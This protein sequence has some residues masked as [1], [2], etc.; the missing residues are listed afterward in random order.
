[1]RYGVYCDD[2][3]DEDDGDVCMCF[4]IVVAGIMRLESAVHFCE[5]VL[6][7]KL[8][9]NQLVIKDGRLIEKADAKISTVDDTLAR[10]LKPVVLM[11][12]APKVVLSPS[13][14]SQTKLLRP[15]TL[16]SVGTQVYPTLLDNTSKLGKCSQQKTGVAAQLG[17]QI[18]EKV[19]GNGTKSEHRVS[20]YRTDVAASKRQL[21]NDVNRPRQQSQRARQKPV[22]LGRLATTCLNSKKCLTPRVVCQVSDC[23]AL[24]AEGDV[25]NV[26]DDTVIATVEFDCSGSEGGKV[27]TADHE[28]DAMDV[29]AGGKFQ[30][31]FCRFS[32][33]NV[34]KI[35]EHNREHQRANNI[36]YYCERRFGSS[37]ELSVHV[38]A[39]H[40]D[41]KTNNMP[42][43][44]SSCPSRFRTRTQL[45]AHLPK[46]SP[47]RP[48]I[49]ATCGASF[50]WRN[51]LHEHAATH[52]SRKEHLCDICGYATAHR[53][54]LRSHRLVHTGGTMCCSWQ[55]CDFRATRM[56]NLKYHLLTHTQEKPH[57]CEVCG[58]SFSLAK[59]MK[60]HMMSHINS[61]M[62]HK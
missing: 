32:T 18:P 36:C 8:Y 58:Q 6:S 56:Q 38:D 25:E 34:R 23:S 33:N 62:K 20:E 21:P 19:S 40:A 44:C 2:D 35:S 57:Q 28:L 30:C 7:G 47:T 17:L 9:S 39:D 27:Q 37:S 48:F 59:N 54:Q 29:D 15:P 1:L 55:G 4:N 53:G 22:K 61:A 24:V 31:S 41:I 14:M 12:D 52:T 43:V 42:F 51:T 49:C 45:V 10:D 16:I 3:E 5:E 11:S 46:H 26:A 50:K 13:Q 60:R